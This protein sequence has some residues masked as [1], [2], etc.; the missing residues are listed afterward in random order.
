[1]IGFTNKSNSISIEFLKVGDD[2]YVIILCG[3][4]AC[5]FPVNANELKEVKKYF[6]SFK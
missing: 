1:M 5:S 3:G 2:L 6:R 4:I